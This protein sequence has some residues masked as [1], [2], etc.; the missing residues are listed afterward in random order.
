[1][2]RLSRRPTIL[3]E[4]TSKPRGVSLRDVCLICSTLICFN[5][6]A[7]CT[8]IE[9]LR[10]C[11]DEESPA[12]CSSDTNK[13]VAPWWI[14]FYMKTLQP[15]LFHSFHPEFSLSIWSKP[16][17]L[18]YLRHYENYHEAMWHFCHDWLFLCPES[19]HRRRCC[20]LTVSSS[21]SGRQDA[22]TGWHE[23]QQHR[24]VWCEW[25]CVLKLACRKHD[26]TKCL[27]ADLQ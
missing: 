13:P 17:L 19:M 25:F 3:T 4:A 11:Y 20:S 26:L 15:W 27:P 6:T 8:Q 9:W 14:A 12:S 7:S 10:N 18:Y 23:Q 1:M 22:T 16:H 2:R 21:V 5:L 24:P